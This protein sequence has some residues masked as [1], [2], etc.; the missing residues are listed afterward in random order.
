MLVRGLKHGLCVLV[1][2][3]RVVAPRAGAWI[4]TG[5]SATWNQADGTSHP[6]RVRGL[7]LLLVIV[8]IDVEEGSHPVRVRGLKLY[9]NSNQSVLQASHPVRVRGLK[10]YYLQPLKILH[11]VAPRAGAWIETFNQPPLYDNTIIVAPRAGAWIETFKQL[12]GSSW[13]GSRTPCGC[14]D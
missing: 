6:V 7:K 2:G 4:E 14:V 3:G 5:Y 1:I 13:D 10:L 11:I 9:K 12:D 8:N